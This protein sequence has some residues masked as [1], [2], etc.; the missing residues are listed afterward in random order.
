MRPEIFMTWGTGQCVEST[1]NSNVSLYPYMFDLLKLRKTLYN[2]KLGNYL[3]NLSKQI[4]VKN[5]GFDFGKDP[6]Q[7]VADG[8]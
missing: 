4:G 1:E 2:T 3:I 5:E 8:N 6:D 7:D